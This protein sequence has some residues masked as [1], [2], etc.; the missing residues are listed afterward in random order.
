MKINNLQL[1]N[2]RNYDKLDINFSD[3]LNIIFG[4]NGSGKTNI[5]EAIYFLSLTKSFRTNDDSNII[6][7]ETPLT[8]I[9]GTV[10]AEDVTKYQLELNNEGKTV[11]IDGDKIKKIS[12]YISRINIVL[13]NPLDTKMISDSPQVRRKILNIDISQ[14]Q[15]EY[16][17][18][19]SDYNKVL[20][21]RNAYLKQ[22]Y[23][24]AN[25]SKEY[26]DILTK[27]LIELGLKIYNFRKEY[28]E[29]INK[30]I[31]NIYKEIFE[32]GKLT[33]KYKSYFANK[34]EEQLLESYQ[35]NYDKEMAFGKTLNGV[36]HDDIV[37]LL[38]GIDIKDYGS[39]GQQKNAIISFKLS[40]LSIMKDYRGHYPILVLDDLFSELD[41]QKI[42]NIIGM[43]N[44]DVQ[45]FIT[46]T[47]IDKI[48]E[49]LLKNSW[50]FKV[51][52]QNVE[53]VE[54]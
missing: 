46:T 43:L 48:D 16:L 39:V 25:S 26:V 44:K 5:I 13:F 17:I 1:K 38:D 18:I 50:I 33:I 7:K 12:D 37:F 28:I 21:H 41:S 35:H 31:T 15:K 11:Y 4:S 9:K 40:E 29:R 42:N 10:V 2:Y 24:S 8:V 34:T 52:K 51:E 30:N 3:K 53:R 32:Y 27:K 6:K 22:L 49:N 45:T 54:I 23:L 47:N 20:K 14:V 19:L 36:H